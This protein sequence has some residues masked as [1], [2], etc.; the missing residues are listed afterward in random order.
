MNHRPNASCTAVRPLALSPLAALLATLFAGAAHAQQAP[1]QEGPIQEVVVTAQKIAQPASKTPLALSVIEA[2]TLRQNG[3][4]NATAL[5]EM[6]PNVQVS[7][8]SGKLQIA[9]RGVASL[10]MTEKGDPS[11]AFNVDGGYVGRPEAQIGSFLDLERIEILRGPQGTLY[12]RNATAG[13]INLITNK[14]GKTFQGKADVDIGNFGTRRAE[15]MLNVPVN[16]LLALR[17]AGTV[18]RR[19]TYYNPGPNTVPL[20]DQDDRAARLHALFSFS[21]ETTLLLTA[22]HSKIGGNGTITVPLTN[23]FSGTPIANGNNLANPV[24]V[25]KGT[26]AQ[27]TAGVKFLNAAN[28]RDNVANALRSEFKTSLGAADL[29]YQFVHLKSTIDQSDNG[30]YFGFPLYSF[31][32]GEALQ[33][34][35]ELR[36]NSVGDVALKWVAGLYHYNEDISRD[37]TYNTQTPGPLIQ[38]PFDSNVHNGS[39]AAFGQVSYKI[40]EGIRATLGLRTTRDVKSGHDPLAGSVTGPGYSA[41][42]SSSKSNYRL[43]VDYDWSRA[44]M[45]Y[46]SLSTGYK[47]GGF[48]DSDGTVYKPESLTSAEAGIKGRFLGNTLRLSAGVFNYDYKDMQLTSIVC[49]GSGPAAQCGSKTTNASNARVSG[50]ELEGTWMPTGDDRLNFGLSGS[51]A[52]FKTYRPTQTDDWSGQS[53]DRAP[54]YTLSLG[55]GHT[56]NFDSGASL[57]A[58]AGTR[59]NG[60]YYLSDTAA[61]VRY[62]QPS[63]HKSDLSLTYNAAQDRYYVQAYARNLEDTVTLESVLPGGFHAGAPRTFGVRAGTTF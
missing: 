36:F 22:E 62:R 2:E 40:G 11:T 13:A 17:F 42:V 24:Y 32:A 59:L 14:P 6:A 39:K 61:A 63:Y 25:D 56:F 21:K 27:L 44:V 30:T 45:L 34:S 48:N 55:Y 28:H 5:T 29:T 51:S 10:D 12:G 54:N 33:K 4:T 49:A 20:E 3:A 43:G 53:L 15:G 16:E 1:L 58:H 37:T 7:S 41:S 23:F 9:I 19:D 18:N 50:V 31:I 8:E 35:H 57:V 26:D 38:V 60:A 47:A 52:Q 46:A